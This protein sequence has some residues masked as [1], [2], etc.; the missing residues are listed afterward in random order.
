MEWSQLLVPSMQSSHLKCQYHA[1]IWTTYNQMNQWFILLGWLAEVC[2][3]RF[4]IPLVVWQGEGWLPFILCYVCTF[5]HVMYWV[6]TFLYIIH[7]YSH[8]L[9]SIVGAVPFYICSRIIVAHQL[10]LFVDC[11]WLKI[12]S[13]V[14]CRIMSCRAVSRC[15]NIG[16]QW[17]HTTFP[18]IIQRL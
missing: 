15:K 7:I 13:I 10:M 3:G 2:L 5:V 9:F 17:H 16:N 1:K 11:S 18:V 4:W 6:A 8:M 12:K 14:S